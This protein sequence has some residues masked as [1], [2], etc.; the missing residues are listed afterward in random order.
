MEIDLLAPFP[1]TVNVDFKRAHPGFQ[2]SAARRFG[3]RSLFDH[4]RRYLNVKNLILDCSTRVPPSHASYLNIGGVVN[5][6][7]PP[8]TTKGPAE[9]I[10]CGFT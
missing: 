1:S 8:S 3:T 2:T 10:V 7:S 5:R 4:L 6:E 9:F